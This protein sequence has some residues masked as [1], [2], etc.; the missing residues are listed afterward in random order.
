M[1]RYIKSTPVD[2]ANTVCQ[3]FLENKGNTDGANQVINDHLANLGKIRKSLS[4][5]QDQILQVYGCASEYQEGDAIGRRL[6]QVIDWLEEILMLALL[7]ADLVQ[8][9]YRARNFSFQKVSFR[10]LF[11]FEDTV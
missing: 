11:S 9:R 7:D 10:N 1:R 5:Y 4:K 6:A 2:F 3:T 8:A